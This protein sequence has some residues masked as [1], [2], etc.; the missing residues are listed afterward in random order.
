MN[1][2]RLILLLT[3]SSWG[4]D[5]YFNTTT[6]VD[7]TKIPTPNPSY[8][9]E[10]EY[11][12]SILLSDE[13]KVGQG[14]FAFGIESDYSNEERSSKKSSFESHL[15]EFFY[16]L[17]MNESIYIDIG[18]KKLNTY[19]SFF[20]APT[21]FLKVN[22]NPKNILS[23]ETSDKLVEG[24]WMLTLEQLSERYSIKFSFLPEVS[25]DD[26]SKWSNLTSTQKREYLL[27]LS[28][29]NDL[30]VDS[31]IYLYK[32]KNDKS[33][34]GLNL[35]SVIGKSVG[36][37]SSFAISEKEKLPYISEDYK[38]IEE[39]E[40]KCKYD[41]V[42]GTNIA[43][44]D[45]STLIAEYLYH[46]KNGNYDNKKRYLKY[47]NSLW[48]NNL[49][50]SA[51]DKLDS[52]ELFTLSRDYLFLRYKKEFKNKFFLETIHSSNLSDGS[53]F[54]LNKIGQASDDKK[55]IVGSQIF[56]GKEESE[57][58]ISPLEWRVFL[59]LEF[60]W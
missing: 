21:D 24:R 39:K 47:A 60:V 45:S 49:D 1:H 20:Y 17:P 33:S 59:E 56:H 12:N 52:F 22:W 57:F 40:I 28:F 8:Q 30:D 13:F 35:N 25:F 55:I 36:L 29:V 43:L 26:D 32:K 51:I 50:S 11:K 54:F 31:T 7:E 41:L 27:S 44:D 10:L 38:S 48:K 16:S 53:G 34:F 18:K 2:F 37:Y 3:I 46:N 58:G 23:K 4:V 42:L 14:K 5:I 9:Q 19:N 15:T 6:R